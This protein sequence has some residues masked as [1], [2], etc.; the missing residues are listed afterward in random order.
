VSIKLDVHVSLGDN[1]G[2]TLLKLYH[3]ST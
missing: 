3:I 1:K 2:S